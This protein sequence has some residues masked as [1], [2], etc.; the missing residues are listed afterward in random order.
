[1]AGV[2]DDDA[3]AEVIAPG[4]ETG[5]GVR[6]VYIKTATTAIA[7]STRARRRRWT[8]TVEGA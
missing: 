8:W 6:L 4:V 1:M 3:D 5:A 2:S 7:A